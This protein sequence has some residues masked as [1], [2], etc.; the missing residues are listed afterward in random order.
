[1]HTHAHL[2]VWAGEGE[3][4]NCG[5]AGLITEENC[6]FARYLSHDAGGWGGEGRSSHLVIKRK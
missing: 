3:S 1:M 5:L 4:V 6:S 2:R